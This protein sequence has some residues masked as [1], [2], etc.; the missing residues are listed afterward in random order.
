VELTY[1]MGTEELCMRAWGNEVA[2]GL[3]LGTADGGISSSGGAL[4]TTPIWKENLIPFS[5]GWRS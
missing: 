5:V 1:E 2:L 3:W 4:L